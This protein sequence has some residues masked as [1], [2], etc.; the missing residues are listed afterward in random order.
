M[1]KTHKTAVVLIPPQE[2]WPPIQ[3]I[4]RLH[5]RQYR[6]WMPHITLIYPF[7]PR[8]AFDHTVPGLQHACQRVAPFELT[9]SELGYFS[10]GRGHYTLWLAPEPRQPVVA[11]QET[12]WQVVPEC[13]EVRRFAQGFTPH[14]SIGQVVGRGQAEAL[15]ERLH[16]H[17]QPPSFWA[18]EVSLIW[19]DDPP[20]DVFRV[21]RH[22]ALAR[23]G[24]AA[25]KS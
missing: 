25:A 22:L 7:W 1:N 5:D 17:W 20:E 23:A 16:H 4:R 11:L 19:R 9:L 14:L 13:N 24:T 12:L 15:R 8:A 3:A 2:I 18:R 6:R 10:H 21:D